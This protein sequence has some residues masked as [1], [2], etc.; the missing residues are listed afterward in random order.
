MDDFVDVHFWVLLC[1]LFIRFGGGL[2]TLKVLD[3]SINQDVVEFEWLE[4]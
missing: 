4:P 1:E 3:L 2:F